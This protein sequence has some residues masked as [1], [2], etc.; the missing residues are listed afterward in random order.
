MPRIKALCS[1]NENEVLAR[2]DQS[3][4]DLI[5][6]RSG[7]GDLDSEAAMQ[8]RDMGFKLLQIKINA[9]VNRSEQGK[10]MTACKSTKNF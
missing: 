3:V 9:M 8:E 7:E 5:S 4:R 6:L 10:M 1:F 2:L